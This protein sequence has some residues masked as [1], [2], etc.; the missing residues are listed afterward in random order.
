MDVGV[1][2]QGKSIKG[3]ELTKDEIF[4]MNK[5]LGPVVQKTLR[6]V[7]AAPQYQAADDFTKQKI[8]ERT[9]DASKTAAQTVNIADVAHRLVG[10]KI[11]REGKKLVVQ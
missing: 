4:K 6:A 5:S 2:G 1:P 7:M 11:T 8:L 3:I 10:K 9:I